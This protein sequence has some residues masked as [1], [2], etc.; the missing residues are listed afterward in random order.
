MR[1][2]FGLYSLVTLFSGFAAA[3]TVRTFTTRN[4][5]PHNRVNWIYPDSKGFLWICTDGGL[6]R[7]DG[8]RFV[9]YTVA[10]GLPHKLINAMIE[11]RA[12]EYWVA[13]DGGVSRYDPSPSHTRFT[14]F[15]PQSS[16]EARHVNSLIEE[17]DGTLLVG[18][19]DGLYRFNPA[20]KPAFEPVDLGHQPTGTL[21]VNGM[22]RDPQGDVYLATNNGLYRRGRD[23]IVTSYQVQSCFTGACRSPDR[24]AFVDSITVDQQG[25]LWVAFRS[26]F[27]RVA[28]EPERKK[29][30][31]DVMI[32]S[33]A[34][35]GARVRGLWFDRDG[36]QWIATDAGL[37]EWSLDAFGRSSFR[38]PSAAEGLG[39]EAITALREG[40]DGSLWVGTRR[41]GLVN[42][43]ESLFETFTGED[44]L[45][46]TL[47]QV[48][49]ESP[50]GQMTVVDI[51]PS[52]RRVFVHE[53]GRSFRAVRPAFPREA[54][55]STR[56]MALVDHLGAWW[57]STAA[58]LFR[59]P[60]MTVPPDLR[61]L[62][63]CAVDRLLE[64]ARGDIWFSH[65]C[66][67]GDAGKLSRWERRTG[68]VHDESVRL[69]KAAHGGISAIAQDRSGAIWLAVLQF[70]DLLRHEN[71]RF[72]PVASWPGHTNRLMLDAKGRLWATSTSWGLAMIADPAAATPEL[73]RYSEA[74]GLNS[75]EVWS[76]VEDRRGQIYVGTS[77]GVSRLDPANGRIVSYTVDDG[78][79]EG[80]VRSAALDAHGDVW[81]A[82]AHGLSRFRP[83]AHQ[84]TVP[85]RPRVTAVRIAGVPAPISDLG[86]P[87][88]V[89]QQLPSDQN[90]L[91]VDF[92]VTDYRLRAPLQYEFAWGSGKPLHDAAWQDLGRS[93]TI[94]LAGISPGQYS[95]RVRAVAP[96][97]PPGPPATV[98]FSIS[99]P[100]WQSAWFQLGA[101]ATVG[102]MA[103]WFRTRRLLQELA[104]ERLRGMI[105]MDLHDEIGAGLSRIA[106]L[107]EA[108]KAQLP[109]A[110]EGPRRMLDDIAASS[111]ELI[112]EMSDI[113]WALDSKR[114]RIDELVGRL[115]AFGSDV[116]EKQGM[117][118][119]V[120]APAEDFDRKLSPAARRQI[121]LVFREAIHNAAKHAHAGEVSLQFTLTDGQLCGTLQDDGVGFEERVSHGA[122]LLSM[123]SRIQR[124]GGTFEVTPGS[125][126]GTL[127]RAAIPLP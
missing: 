118:W 127:V 50:S 114:D 34:A 74:D 113:V 124:I 28:Q 67:A 9:S 10:H 19:S 41:S 88:V 35:L 62:P 98:S 106:I 90:S 17:E 107:G 27:G 42:L 33:P 93:G 110:D 7:F 23:G 64:D 72:R 73:R 116:L 122:G 37:H 61:L 16:E 82:S 59:F 25:R 4:G 40:L 14:T 47:D 69:P 85:P 13:S 43:A 77:R 49:L 89:L 94:H 55:T 126:G 44:G 96:G 87:D 75:D 12:G 125:R 3:E 68:E 11:T 115:R 80:D 6:A 18:T 92:A 8:A 65:W 105:A 102:G 78:L 63:Q 21:M 45:R 79:A 58:G 39:S 30:L 26:G 31:L 100:F 2:V 5:L 32:A 112:R 123:A 109:A 15:A 99:V 66:G 51:G 22:I 111:R 46:L 60:S 70:G 83:L 71:G 24:P 53:R 95:L 103:Y 29:R 104:I 81:F 84:V 76:V 1:F 38:T 54:R 91:Q 48:L 57:F 86:E 101:I 56:Q 20:K 36:R 119:T 52:E 121:Y 117:K 108:A 97:G 120:Q